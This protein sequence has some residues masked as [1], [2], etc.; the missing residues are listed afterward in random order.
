MCVFSLEKLPGM[1]APKQYV[2]VLRT[3]GPLVVVR[4]IV[5]A[6]SVVVMAVVVVVI[7][8]IVLM[9]LVTTL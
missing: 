8:A 7:V 5:T 6:P 1:Q 9:E 3:H 2:A 4:L